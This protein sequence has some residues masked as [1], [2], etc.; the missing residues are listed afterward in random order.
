MNKIGNSKVMELLT[1][2]FSTD[3]HASI[4]WSSNGWT[5][6]AIGAGNLRLNICE[7]YE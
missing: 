6:E 7:K 3:V 2:Q 1:R 4:A 5:A